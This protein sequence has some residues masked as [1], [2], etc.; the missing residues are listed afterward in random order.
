[1]K[2]T[3]QCVGH[4]VGQPCGVVE[5]GDVTMATLM[6]AKE[7]EDVRRRAVG[8]VNAFTL[9]ASC[10]EVVAL[11]DDALFTHVNGLDEGV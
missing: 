7:A 11:A 6:H 4:M 8:G 2:V 9:E 10:V 3:R 1:M 5:S